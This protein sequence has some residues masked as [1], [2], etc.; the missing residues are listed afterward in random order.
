MDIKDIN[1]IQNNNT[2]EIDHQEYS[3]GTD[4]VKDDDVK[5]FDTTAIN[6]LDLI[7][8]QEPDIDVNQTM[9]KMETDYDE[10]MTCTHS[11]SERCYTSYATSYVPYQEEECEEKFLKTCMIWT[12]KE[13][14]T[15][16]VDECTNSLVPDCSQTGPEMCRTVYD[17]V[18]DTRQE[19]YEVEEQFPNCRLVNTEKCRERKCRVWPA[20]RCTV[21]TL[22]VRHSLPST[23]CRRVPRQ[24]CVPGN[25][26]LHEAVLCNK[27]KKMVLIDQPME[28]CELEPL[29]VCQQVTK[30]LPKLSKRKEC[31][32]V[33]KEVCATSRLNPKIKN[34][35]FVKKLYFNT[36]VTPRPASIQFLLLLCIH[37]YLIFI[38]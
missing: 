4:H 26:L 7:N 32:K 14:V 16:M 1:K 6:I 19:T 13:A 20:Q 11:Y 3:R 18:C 31:V 35:P 5:D 33:P 36:N 17:T 22:T 12:E 27:K 29:Q 38:Y 25:C 30:L 24:L 23:G 9:L 15:E 37:N 10:I 2:T 34:V 8:V 28:Q 21:E